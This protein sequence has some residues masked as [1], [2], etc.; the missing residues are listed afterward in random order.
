[1]IDRECFMYILFGLP[2]WVLVDGTW[3]ILSQLSESLPESYQI[4]SYLILALTI[5]NIIPLF[6]GGFLLR[7]N[8]SIRL[9]TIIKLIL[10]IG[11]ITGLCL[12]LFWDRTISNYSIPL[13]ILFF[14]VGTCSSSSNVTHFTYVSTSKQY[15][16]TYLATGMGLGSM[17]SGLLALIQGLVLINYGFTVSYYYLVLSLCYIPALL[18]FIILEK[19]KALLRGDSDNDNQTLL[20]LA[21]YNHDNYVILTESDN[22]HNQITSNS[23]SS[24]TGSEITTIDDKTND[25]LYNENKFYMI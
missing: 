4:S 21:N 16:T 10:V 14:V 8:S 17:I 19:H 5:G 12:S 1:M 22:N 20:K 6:I 7:E 25:D 9:P 2:T 18:M 3:S 23:N 13:Y 15:N 24:T 11:F